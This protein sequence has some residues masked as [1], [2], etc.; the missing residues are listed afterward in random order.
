M[1]PTSPVPTPRSMSPP[2]RRLSPFQ[3]EKYELPG[4]GL[5]APR[6]LKKPKKILY[7]LGIFA[8]LY[9][10]GIRHGLGMER[11]RRPLGYYMPGRRRKSMAIDHGMAIVKSNKEHPIFELM[12][13][14]EEQWNRL[15]SSQ[16]K[17]LGAAVNE[18]KKR[19]NISPPLGFDK[20]WAFCETHN[21]TIRDDYDHIMKDI[22]LHHA[23]EPAEWRKRALAMDGEEMTYTMKVSKR[24]GVALT[25]ER[26][27]QLRPLS[28]RDLVAGFLKEM[29]DGFYTQIT[30]S[31]HDAGSQV[32]GNDQRLR[33]ME[34]FK[35][36]Q[37]EWELQD[38]R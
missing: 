9:W 12:E 18:Y 29:P 35:K 14:G 28:M 11:T 4:A 2:K 36:G 34:L 22:L 15:L 32:V 3:R 25:G 6:G 1:A 16:S 17:T 23:L 5:K 10:F 33:A 21:I 31:D 20:W 37:R 27:E 7:L 26:A 38:G 30:V 13:R 8:L 19:Y 24:D